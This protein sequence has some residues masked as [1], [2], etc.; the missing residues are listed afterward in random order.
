MPPKE[1]KVV[2]IIRNHNDFRAVGPT[3][4]YAGRGIEYDLRNY[5]RNSCRN[6]DAVLYH[7][8][9]TPEPPYRLTI[10]LN[11]RGSL[12]VRLRGDHTALVKQS[13]PRGRGLIC[14]FLP[15]KWYGLRV[16][17][18]VEAIGDRNKA[19]RKE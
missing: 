5:L 14:C 8:P 19:K 13:N 2:V 9:K 17:R 1:T 15:R 10:Y 4:T 12:I 3:Q 6:Y 16:S 7:F 18:K 11:K